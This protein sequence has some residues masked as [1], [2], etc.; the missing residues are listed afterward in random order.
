MDITDSNLQRSVQIEDC[1][2]EIMQCVPYRRITIA[3]LCDRVGIARKTFYYYYPSKDD[4]LYA[5]VDRKI[6]EASLYT[7]SAL[8]NNAKHLESYLSNLNFWKNQKPFLDAL[9]KNDLG[10]VFLDR[11]MRYI[12]QEEKTLT[13]MLDTDAVKF[14]SDILLFYMCGQ[15]SMMFQWYMRG[16]DTSTEEMAKKYMRLIH[17]P[18][19]PSD[20]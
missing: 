7:A 5:I 14:D 2:L 16:F 12:V 20:G 13:D 1:L 17:A 9:V 11:Y 19:L 3:E 8:P 15:I 10:S 4:C 18:I 6:E